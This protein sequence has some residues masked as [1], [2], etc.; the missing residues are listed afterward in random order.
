MHFILSIFKDDDMISSS[1][2]KHNPKIPP[3]S[4]LFPTHPGQ[5]LTG[6]EEEGGE[7][8]H[9]GEPSPG[10]LGKEKG[11]LFWTE[12]SWTEEKKM[13]GGE[14]KRR[15]EWEEKVEKEVRKKGRREKL[16]EF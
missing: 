15:G 16:L 5:I 6:K 2:K 13:R 3:P 8:R 14:G 7:Q 4:T 1:L 10:H 9:H 12:P 11:E